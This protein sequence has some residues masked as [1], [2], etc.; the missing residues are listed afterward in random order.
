MRKILAAF[1]PLFLLMGCM[2]NQVSEDQLK[3]EISKVPMLYTVEA[4][5]EVLVEGHGQNGTAEWKSIFGQRDIIVPV[6]ANVKA[7]IDISKIEDLEI[8]GDR[9]YFS[10]PDPVIE[11]ESS[12]IPW[13][14]VVSSVTGFRDKFS[15]QEKEF[16]TRKGRIKI[17]SQLSKLDLI[18]PAQEH[19]EATIA[20]II[21]SLGYTPVLKAKPVY[22]ENEIIRFVKE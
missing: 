5:V 20:N 10:L 8:S 11:I 9:V 7:G 12:E 16:L 17:L 2:G 14:E 1:L 21:S 3:A 19:A 13:D 4:E 6:R 22:A 18:Q 15:S